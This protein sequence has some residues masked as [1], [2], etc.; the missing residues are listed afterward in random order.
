[1]Q[2][3]IE[4]AAKLDLAVSLEPKIRACKQSKE[5]AQNLLSENVKGEKNCLCCSF[6]VVRIF[7]RLE[8]K[9]SRE[10]SLYV[11]RKNRIEK[12]NLNLL[13]YHLPK[14]PK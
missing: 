11:I 12:K 7:C 9:R 3:G 14:M 6:S 2:L 10:N 5:P 4:T 8:G 1:M 13:R